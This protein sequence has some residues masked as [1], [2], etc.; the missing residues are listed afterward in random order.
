M[1]YI[2]HISGYPSFYQMRI[3]LCMHYKCTT[4]WDVKVHVQRTSQIMIIVVKCGVALGAPDR[5]NMPCF[6][7]DTHLCQNDIM[8][9][10][11]KLL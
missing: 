5:V 8:S 2:L 10:Q 3:K 4:S 9:D 6:M 11:V 1:F 7:H